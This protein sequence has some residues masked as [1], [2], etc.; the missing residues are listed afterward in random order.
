MKPL[1]T[2]EQVDLREQWADE[3]RGFTVWLSTDGLELLGETIGADLVLVEREA[4]V[5]PFS[6]DIL[7]QMEGE[8]EHLVIIENQL[9]RTNHDHLGK[10]ITYASGLGA[11]TVVWVA[12]EFTDEHRQALDWLNAR[13][14]DGASFFG[15]EIVLWKIADSP[16]APQFRIVSR[17]NAWT[18]VVRQT[19]RGE[20]T[21]TKIQQRDFWQELADYMRSKGTFLSLRMP[22][23][24]HWYDIALGRS[25]VHISLTI[26]SRL[27]RVGCEI[28]MGGEHAKQVYDI[29]YAK[30]DRI[31]R[32]LG[33]TLDWRRLDERKAARAI[34]YHEGSISDPSQREEIKEWI[35][36]TAE[37]LH[38]VFAPIVT[39][40]DVISAEDGER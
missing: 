36:N 27:K 13:T 39:G 40:M 26:N 31:E 11:R 9:D 14:D 28:Y 20:P 7:A 35:R 30:K 12:K 25:N 16:S 33:F 15:L 38:R 19:P 37:K 29:L 1:S 3:A 24:Q 32:D 10:V 18:K 6:A 5:G 22:Q 34:V 17:P 8:D 4:S 21:E 2:L 23:P